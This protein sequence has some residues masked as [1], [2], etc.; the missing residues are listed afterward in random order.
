MSRT[1]TPSLATT[2]NLGEELEVVGSTQVVE[3]TVVVAVDTFAE[4]SQIAQ[5]VVMDAT[6]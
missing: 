3:P 2:Q 4:V 6:Q 1:S 5:D